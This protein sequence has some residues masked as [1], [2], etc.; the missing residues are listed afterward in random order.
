MS[1]SRT[2]YGTTYQI[3][4]KGEKSWGPTVTS[5]LLALGAGMDGL[6]LKPG[7]IPLLKL[8]LQDLS[9]AGGA[10]LSWVYPWHRVQGTSGAVTLS[11]STPIAVGS[12]AGQLL[13]LTGKHATNTVRINDGGNATLNGDIILA[14][15]DALVLLWD[16]QLAKWQEVFRNS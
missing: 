12:T 1:Q 15:G 7:S 8:P 14:L 6:S 2:L 16:D 9:L 5:F 10:T 13:V 11:A 3:P 4:E